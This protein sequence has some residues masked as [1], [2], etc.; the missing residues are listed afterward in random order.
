M[1]AGVGGTNEADGFRAGCEATR[2][3]LDDTGTD[4]PD[5]LLAFASGAVD[6]ERFLAGVRAVVGD[7]PPVVGGSAVGV[8]TRDGPSLDGHP[9]AVAALR[10]DGDHVAHVDAASLADGE[11]AAGERLARGLAASAVADPSATTLL[12]YDSVRA[13]PTDAAP[14]ALYASRPLLEGLASGHPTGGPIVGAGLLGDYAFSPSVQYVGADVARRHAVA[15]AL[16]ASVRTHTRVMHGCAPLDGV[17]HRLG[18]VD[19]AVVRTIDGRP[20]A[21]FLDGLYGSD[22]WRAQR[23]VDRIAL[24]VWDPAAAIGAGGGEGDQVI[25]LITGVLPDGEAIGLFEPDLEDGAEV[26]LMVRDPDVTV[27]SA[28]VHAEAAVAEA[29]AGGLAPRLAL[30]VDCA[31]RAARVSRTSTEEAA[32]VQ[33]VTSRHGIPLLGLYSGVEIAPVGGRSRGL[34]W[35]GVLLL[36]GD[37][38]G[39]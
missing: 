4:A 15:A 2:A 26:V 13:P 38:D 7:G 17:P 36:V 1:R 25:R 16:P 39:R 9:A 31:G 24:G 18:G 19:G 29:L 11:R 34:D 23:P 10:F 6:A 14:P 20:A 5:L 8:I 37:A 27:E 32:E 33:A 3:A 22:G 30:Y 12:F 35:T 21:A 28:R